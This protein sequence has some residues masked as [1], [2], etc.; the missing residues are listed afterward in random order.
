MKKRDEGFTLVE[1]MVVVLIIAI[2]IAIAIPT[3]LGARHRAQDRAAQSNL[4]N[5]LTA[6]KV[7]YSDAEDYNFAVADLDNIHAGLT[8]VNNNAP[9][10][11]Q[12]GYLILA[13][14][15]GAA[16][17]SVVFVAE[18]NSGA[19]FCLLDQ[20]SGSAAGAYYGVSAINGAALDTL[21]EC[22]G[23]WS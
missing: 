16:N 23:G 14:T 15:D 19:W 13:N 4:R 5:S 22:I 21:A 11:G 2:L 1:L 12:V 7:F 18:S 9:V 3:F 8:Y 17:Q 6:A 10:A 20:A